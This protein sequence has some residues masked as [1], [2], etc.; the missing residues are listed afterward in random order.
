MSE[1][2]DSTLITVRNLTNCSVSYKI[3]EDN[4]RVVFRTNE[5]KKI[6]AGELR[7]LYFKP[8]GES[9]LRNYLW[10][11]NKA[12]R[13][14][15]NIPNNVPEYEWTLADVARIVEQG[16]NDEIMDALEF[17]PKGIADAIVDYAIKNKIA[18][19]NKRKAIQEITGINVDQAIHLREEADAALGLN[20]V[21]TEVRTRRVSPAP[22]A[23][24]RRVQ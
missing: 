20:N 8:G 12:L 10:I 21:E 15:F 3:P 2:L 18:D 5:S 6:T 19:S 24:G 14:E 1:V 11:D 16:S 17:G 22:A 7:K 4:R 9:M 23:S 13:A